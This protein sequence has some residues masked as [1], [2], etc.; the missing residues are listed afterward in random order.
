[1]LRTMC[2]TFAA[3]LL[4]SAHTQAQLPVRSAEQGLHGLAYDFAWRGED[5]TDAKARAHLLVHRA[6]YS[7]APWEYLELS[8]GAG[9]ARYS[10][11]EYGNGEF[12]GNWQFT[13]SAGLVL[14]TPAIAGIVRLRGALDYCWWQSEDSNIEYSAHVLDPALSLVWN[15]KRFDVEM[16]V[17]THMDFGT[18]ETTGKES[19]FSNY[20]VP[21][22]FAALTILLPGRTFMRLHGDVS[23]EVEGW[24][25]G[26]TESTIGLSFGWLSRSIETE[27]PE[28]AMRHFP[29]VPELRAK[30]QQMTDELHAKD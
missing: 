2:I 10:I 11:Y 20:Y 9:A 29:A 28:P 27:S 30:Q 17:L 1:M 13:P 14:N 12:E 3:S 25:G 15:A 21:R 19:D 7:W 5:I 18:M 4:L 8:L 23:T 24:H 26:P 6:V 16:G 22:G